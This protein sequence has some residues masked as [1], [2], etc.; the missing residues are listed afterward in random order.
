M[1]QV[2]A[3][4]LLLALVFYGYMKFLE[5]VFPGDQDSSQEQPLM[6]DSELPPATCIGCGCDD[7]HA[8]PSELF[9]SCYWLRVDRELCVGVCSGCPFHLQRWDSGE[10]AVL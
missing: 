3:A 7:L 9:G 6:P 4:L 8:C 2:I 1:M 5:L 10:R